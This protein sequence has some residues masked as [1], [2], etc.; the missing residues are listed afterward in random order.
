[1]ELVV[2]SLDALLALWSREVK[3]IQC[4]CIG[5]L[6]FTFRRARF[7]LHPR[8]MLREAAMLMQNQIASNTHT[9]H[10]QQLVRPSPPSTRGSP[11]ASTAAAAAPPPAAARVSPHAASLLR[12]P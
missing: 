10:T 4:L 5:C 6:F 3:K 2:A 1:M 12:A 8:G 9:E 11:R 7:F